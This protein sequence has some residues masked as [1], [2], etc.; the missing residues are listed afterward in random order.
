[1]TSRFGSVRLTQRVSLMLLVLS[2]EGGTASAVAVRPRFRADFMQSPE[3]DTSLRNEN[4]L[5]VALRAKD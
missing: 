2:P 5:C 4:E 1:M 3:G